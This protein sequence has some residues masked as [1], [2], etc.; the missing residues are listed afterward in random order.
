[1]DFPKLAIN[2]DKIILNVIR[3]NA[4]Y[5]VRFCGKPCF[6]IHY[7]FQKIRDSYDLR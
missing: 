2:S 7:L 4:S 3:K 5:R 1:M 6:R